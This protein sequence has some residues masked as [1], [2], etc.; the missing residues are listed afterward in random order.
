MILVAE[1]LDLAKW[2]VEAR[3]EAGKTKQPGWY[4]QGCILTRCGEQ[5]GDDLI[6]GVLLT[7]CCYYSS[8][9]AFCEALR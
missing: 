1:V 4:M 7:G 9:Q 5:T 8:Y 3:G 6:V 2:W